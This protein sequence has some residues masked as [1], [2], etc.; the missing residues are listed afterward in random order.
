MNRYSF[1]LNSLLFRIIVYVLY[2]IL[3]SVF[4]FLLKYILQ[5][6]HIENNFVPILLFFIVVC[7]GIIHK[8]DYRNQ[9][10]FCFIFNLPFKIKN[11]IIQNLYLLIEKLM[12]FIAILFCL[13][14]AYC[15]CMGKLPNVGITE[16]EIFNLASIITTV[17]SIILTSLI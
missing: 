5:M 6:F 4:Y 10:L 3:T 1:N 17:V 2:A 12:S 15:I 9:Q 7:I 14:C 8:K 16:K 11:F 13:F